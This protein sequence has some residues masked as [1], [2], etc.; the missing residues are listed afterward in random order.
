LLGICVGSSILA[1]TGL[2]DGH[3]ATTNSYWFDRS[4]LAHPQVHWVHGVRYVDDAAVITSTNL[5]SGVD[6]TLH[7]VSRLVSRSVADDVAR[8]LGYTHTTYL[9]APRF[10]AP[11]AT[12]FPPLP[13]A[14]NDMF[15]W[16]QERL[17]VL[18]S[19]GV[20]EF[21]L[22]ALLDPYT[23]SLAAK[24]QLFA[25]SRAPIVSRDGLVFLPRYDFS[26]VPTL[27]RVVVP[28]GDPTT[29]R[30]QAIAAWNQLRP[31]R[32]VQEIHR[33]VGPGE[34]AYE[35]SLQDLGRHHNGMIVV[36]VADSLNVPTNSL[37]LTDAAWPIEPIGAHLLLGLLGVG[38]VLL[39]SRVPLRR[40]T[41]PARSYALAG[42]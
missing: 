31:D 16:P 11:P 6:A 42:S 21:A 26:T 2:L 32:L 34:S 37:Q 23:A 30:Q 8:Q 36:P 18:L 9:D 25:L 3:Q 12:A 33:D 5:A 29:A 7:T 40:R 14:E 20:S 24:P 19:D 39:I 10:H 17:G 13:L 4:S 28:G 35:A 27:D 15:E 38:L 1:D 41:A 22:A